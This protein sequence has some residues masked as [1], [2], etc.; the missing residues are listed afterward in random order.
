MAQ[1][2]ASSFGGHL[3]RKITATAFFV[4]VLTTAGFAQIPSSGNVFFGY[5]YMGADLV[6]DNRTNLNGWDASIEGKVFPFVGIVADFSGHYGSQTVPAVGLNASVAQHD[7]LFGPRVSTSV[8]KYRPFAHALFGASHISESAT[9]F[10]NS[11]TAFAYALGGGLDYRLLRLIGWRLQV[12]FL[13]TR[14]F[15]VSQNDVRVSTGL[16]VHF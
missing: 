4:F 6:P 16:V 15:S 13:Q 2:H 14:F 12:D 11:N 5:S 3:A 10:P 7:F 9:G 1:R 8:G